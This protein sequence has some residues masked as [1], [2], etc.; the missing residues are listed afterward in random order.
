MLPKSPFPRW[1]QVRI[2][3]KED[4]HAVWK[5][6]NSSRY[7]LS[8]LEAPGADLLASLVSMGQR[9]GTQL[10]QLPL[11]QLLQLQLVLDQTHAQ[12]HSKRHRLFDRSSAPLELDISETQIQA[13]VCPFAFYL[14]VSLC[15]T[16][17]FSS[18][19]PALL[20]Y[21]FLRP[22]T[23]PLHGP[24]LVIFLWCYPISFQ[25]YTCLALAQLHKVKAL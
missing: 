8:A 13:P 11:D 15:F 14:T 17:S 1:F 19:L 4:L 24:L 7:A 23:A 9:Q 5:L 6:H 18:Q 16:A 25:N 22:T 3:H 21:N 20:T 2:A 10:L 12:L